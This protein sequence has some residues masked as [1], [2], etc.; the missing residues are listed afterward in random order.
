MK[1][2]LDRRDLGRRGR[3]Q[4]MVAERLPIGVVLA[5]DFVGRLPATLFE[6]GVDLIRREPGD[7][8]RRPFVADQERHDDFSLTS[9]LISMMPPGRRRFSSSA[10]S[11]CM[12]P[13][14]NCL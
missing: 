8:M 9:A 12:T 10:V 11:F 7:R 6:A 2:A 4:R 3:E 13:Y 1:L 5:A 14:G